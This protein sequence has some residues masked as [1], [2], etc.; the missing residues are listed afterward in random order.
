MHQHL[1]AAILGVLLAAPLAALAQQPLRT[2]DPADPGA[3]VPPIV[4]ESAFSRPAAAPQ[5]GQPTPDKA[6]RAANDA[7]ASAAS[8]HA[9]HA[10]HGAQG[11]NAHAEPAAAHGTSIPAAARQP[12]P[13]DHSKHH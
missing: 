11:G 2:P 4:Y 9:G 12:V 10:G 13:V 3:A 8:E 6:W 5:D 7:V 1:P